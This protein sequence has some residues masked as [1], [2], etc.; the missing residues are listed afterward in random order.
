V[1]F[2][3]ISSASASGMAERSII[4]AR[5]FVFALRNTSGSAISEHSTY[6][7]K[8]MQSPYPAH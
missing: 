8:T 3:K 5:L 7:V 2:F 6:H 1:A 4:S